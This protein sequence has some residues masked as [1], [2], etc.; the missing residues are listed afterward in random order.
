MDII[1]QGDALEVNSLYSRNMQYFNQNQVQNM[2]I[3]VL[4]CHSVSK[5]DVH[6]FIKMLTSFISEPYGNPSYF[7]KRNPLNSTK[8][9][10]FMAFLGLLMD[11]KPNLSSSI[12]LILLIQA[13]IK[14]SYLGLYKK[15]FLEIILTKS[16]YCSFN[17][18]SKSIYNFIDTIKH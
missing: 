4:F 18:A 14:N 16:F 7:N 11:H 3:Y 15:S 10:S 12:K 1:S 6:M 5:S 13:S 17:S 9:L 8:S 2:L